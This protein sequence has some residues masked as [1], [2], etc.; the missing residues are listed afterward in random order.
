VEGTVADANGSASLR[1]KYDAAVG[2]VAWSETRIV[3]DGRRPLRYKHLRLEAKSGLD[4]RGRLRALSGVCNYVAASNPANYNS[5]YSEHD[6]SVDIA[7]ATGWQ[8]SWLDGRQPP[9][10][11]DTEVLAKPLLVDPLFDFSMPV[12]GLMVRLWGMLVGT[13]VR[14]ARGD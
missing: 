13:K 2:R 4:Q 8:S 12:T 3:S 1:G 7:D 11:N 5:A 10:V 9:L 14:C 6:G